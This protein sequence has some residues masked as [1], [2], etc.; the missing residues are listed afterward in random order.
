[1]AGIA[2]IQPVEGNQEKNHQAHG[3][4]VRTLLDGQATKA[5]IIAATQELIGG[6]ASG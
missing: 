4:A 6:A 2:A 1:L 3:F 5:G